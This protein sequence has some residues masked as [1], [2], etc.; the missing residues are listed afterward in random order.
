MKHVPPPAGEPLVDVPLPP[1][2]QHAKVLKALARLRKEAADEVEKLLAFLDETDGDADLEPSLGAPESR[3]F[4]GR[5]ALIWARGS[6]DLE[7][8]QHDDDENGHDDE[9]WL[10]WTP[11]GCHGNDDREEEH[12][13]SEPGIDDEP[14]L[15]SFDRMMNQEK[16]WRQSSLVAGCDSEV[17]DCDLEEN[18]DLEPSFGASADQERE[19]DFSDIEPSLGWTADGLMG[20]FDDRED[21]AGPKVAEARRRKRPDVHSNAGEIIAEC[22]V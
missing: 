2:E 8:T 3:Y 5:R 7:A 1:P 19:Q 9:P 10:G 13:G 18:G 20:G 11:T 6:D 21:A 15:G 4:D 22:K 12:D 14:A 17:D 16:S